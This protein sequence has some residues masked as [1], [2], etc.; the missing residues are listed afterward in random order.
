MDRIRA[1][2]QHIPDCTIS[3]DIIAGFCGETEEDH[4]ETLSIM[5][6]A[7]FDFAYMFRYSE[8]SGTIAAKKY[9]D[10]VPGDVKSR[11]LDEIIRL[12]QTLSLQS[13]EK[14]IGKIAE[15]LVE[16]RSRKSQHHLSGRNSQNKV[17]VFPAR[18]FK[19]GEY[20]N[21]R[22]TGCTSATLT[23]EASADRT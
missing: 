21:V 10:D 22:I 20:I 18:D 16:G 15:V 4:L 11:R 5:T 12:Q 14:D 9:N 19:P 13:N 8:R 1:I 2:R 3:T 23:G 6:E 17:V 7:A